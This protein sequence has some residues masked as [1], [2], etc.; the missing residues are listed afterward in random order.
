MG[1]LK[2]V[3]LQHQ[4]QHEDDFARYYSEMYMTAGYMGA[5]KIFD[6]LYKATININKTKKI[7]NGR[8]R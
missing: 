7:K 3:L 5:E 1:K 2:E 4:Q 8:K 6:T